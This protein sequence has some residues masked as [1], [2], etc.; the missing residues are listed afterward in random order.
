MDIM[1]IA[2][3]KAMMGGGSVGGGVVDV[4]VN[5]TSSGTELQATSD[6]TAKQIYEQFAS[7]KVVRIILHQQDNARDGAVL[8][9]TGAYFWDANPAVGSEVEYGIAASRSEWT[10]VDGTITYIYFDSLY[11]ETIGEESAIYANSGQYEFS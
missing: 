2:M 11:F 4:D 10:E 6:Y 1:S 3:A 7:G 9:I 5:I 8:T